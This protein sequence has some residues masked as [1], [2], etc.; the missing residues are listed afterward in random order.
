M[1]ITAE[2]KSLMIGVEAGG[3]ITATAKA[4]GFTQER[5]GYG[6]QNCIIY[7]DFNDGSAEGKTEAIKLAIRTVVD[8][9]LTLPPELR[10]YCIGAEVQNRAFVR[11]AGWNSVSYITLGPSAL[12]PGNLQSISNSEHPGFS[13]GT[14]TCIHEI[15]HCLHALAKGESFLST[16]DDGG[17]NGEPTGANA[18]QVSG[19]AGLSKKEFVAEVFVGTVIGRE[20]ADSVMTEYQLYGGPLL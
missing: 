16:N 12:E 15:G 7:K 11:D 5:Y 4:K 13:K 9:G 14:V 17:V 3:F 8:Y 18:V 20:Y 6:G 10:I 19:Y 1:A 2:R